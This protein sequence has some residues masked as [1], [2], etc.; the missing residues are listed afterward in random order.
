MF[1]WIT[2]IWQWGVSNVGDPVASWTR[3]FIHG[4][5]GWLD[6]MFGHIGDAWHV[7]WLSSFA[8]DIASGNFGMA[9][10]DAF[11]RLFK[12]AIP[13]LIA[14]ADRELKSLGIDLSKLTDWI[15]KR[16]EQIVARIVHDITQLARWVTVH[17]YDPLARDFLQAWHWITHEGALVF[18]I[19][20]HPDKLVNLI[21][22]AL[23][24]KLEAEA[25]N[26]GDRLG[27]FFLS[28]IIHNIRKF[29]LLMEDIIMAVF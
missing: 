22:D 17:I 25:W 21:W 5:F 26:I 2:R 9:I 12:I 3:D 18:D 11:G 1:G 4:V 19:I 23:T 28:L 10:A 16:I 6:T 7:M 14:W 27:K 20:T 13:R 29:A 8:V 15:V 24:G